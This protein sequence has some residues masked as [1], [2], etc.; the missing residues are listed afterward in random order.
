MPQE[1]SIKIQGKVGNRE[2]VIGKAKLDG[3]RFTK[4]G[5]ALEEERMVIQIP[6]VQ[7]PITILGQL[8][9]IIGATALQVP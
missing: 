2:T 6:F 9:V 8:N 4:M 3:A 1:F 7:G 5:H